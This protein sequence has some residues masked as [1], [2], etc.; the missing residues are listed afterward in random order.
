MEEKIESFAER[1]YRS[2][3]IDGRMVLKLH[4]ERGNNKKIEA[5]KIPRIYAAI[6]EG[7]D[8]DIRFAVIEGDI[9]TELAG[10]EK[11]ADGKAIISGRITIRESEINGTTEFRGVKFEQETGFALTCFRGI[12]DFEGAT[13]GHIAKFSGS[14]FEAGVSFRKANFKRTAMFAGTR[15]KESAPWA[16]NLYA[17]YREA[18]SEKV[19]FSRAS[20][21]TIANFTEAGFG[22]AI[23]ITARFEQA[24]AFTGAIEI[25]EKNCG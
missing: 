9:Y 6:R 24:A 3:E 1:E 10:L 22:E 14:T 21:K 5:D 16:A 4:A 2:Q 15:F 12:A 20:F 11:D 18:R 19:D 23:F 17:D 7:R 13:F 8:V 25:T